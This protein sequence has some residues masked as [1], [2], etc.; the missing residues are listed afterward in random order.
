MIGSLLLYDFIVY[1]MYDRRREKETQ[2]PKILSNIYSFP[3]LNSVYRDQSSEFTSQ[4][5]LS[6]CVRTVR[7]KIPKFGMIK[8]CFL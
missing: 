2:K 4:G 3:D 6:T 5:Y 1:N 7:T 8:N